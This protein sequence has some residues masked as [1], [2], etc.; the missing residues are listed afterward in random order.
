MCCSLSD[1]TDSGSRRTRNRTPCVTARQ[2]RGES[3]LAGQKAL[4]TGAN[5]GIG[6]AIAIALGKAG[7]DVAVNY[8]HGDQSACATMGEIRQAGVKA[9]AH[10]ADVGVEADVV[11][12]FD[13]VVREFGTVDIV[14]ANAGNQMDAGFADMSLAEWDTVMKGNLTGQL[15]CARAAVREFL[16]RGVNNQVSRAAGK[17]ICVSSVHQVNPWAGHVNYAASK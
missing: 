11:S 12:M 2:A 16:R 14:V 17:I 1:W 6:K 5:T 4:V 10:R 9:F 7:A 15:L 8:L 13:H 3:M